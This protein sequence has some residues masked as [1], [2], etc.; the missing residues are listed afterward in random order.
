MVIL[1]YI[2]VYFQELVIKT[3]KFIMRIRKF[4][5]RS[6]AEV[7]KEHEPP[8][9]FDCHNREQGKNDFLICQKINF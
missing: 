4:L 3:F 8:A 2:S 9:G 1:A 5:Y 6:P 7:L